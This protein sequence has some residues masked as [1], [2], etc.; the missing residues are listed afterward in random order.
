MLTPDIELRRRKQS[1]LGQPPP[2]HLQFPPAHPTKPHIAPAS[3]VRVQLPPA[4]DMRHAELGP[5]ASVQPPPPQ[6]TVHAPP[7]GHDVLQPPI[8]QSTLHLF[9]P[10][11]VRHFPFVQS[12]AH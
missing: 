5:H 9:A 3:H 2:S 10:Q 1:H 6:F 7:F 11:Y 8:E 12:T 4:H